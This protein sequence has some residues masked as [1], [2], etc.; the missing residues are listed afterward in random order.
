MKI[1]N[2]RYVSDAGDMI[3]VDMDGRPTTVVSSDPITKALFVRAKAGEFGVV[4]PFVAPPA[5]P[6]PSPEDEAR[7]LVM[8]AFGGVAK[9]LSV[10]SYF[11]RIAA[12]TP[13]QR[14][15]EEKA[16]LVTLTAADTWEE[17]MLEH[18]RGAALTSSSLAWPAEPVGLAALVEAC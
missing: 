10:Q 14:S 18:A 13:A 9:R 1:T 11:A 17:A 2:P 3:D 12:K 5:P 6:A 15:D 16:D 4:A 7:R 8:A